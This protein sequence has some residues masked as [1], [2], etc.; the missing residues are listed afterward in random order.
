MA[1]SAECKLQFIKLRA[2]GFSYSEISKKLNISKPVQVRWNKQFERLIES[3][4][5]LECEKLLHEYKQTV[6]DRFRTNCQIIS[7]LDDE[8]MKRDFS[9][10][11]TEK[12][13]SMRTNYIEQLAQVYQI[14]LQMELKISIF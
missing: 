12:L 11:P 13:L 3:S 4:K 14:S 5:I 1:K 7:K 2:K 8:I 10:I 9:D 6:F